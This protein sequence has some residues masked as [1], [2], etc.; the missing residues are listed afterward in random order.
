M[1]RRCTSRPTSPP[2]EGNKSARGVGAVLRH[3]VA[4][5]ADVNS[6]FVLDTP[7]FTRSGSTALF[8]ACTSLGAG[9]VEAIETL[10]E[11]GAVDR[12]SRFTYKLVEAGASAP[13][14]PH[15]TT[16]LIDAAGD[17]LG[18]RP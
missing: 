8:A 4:L 2:R 15:E 18:A 11:L 5:G 7:Q 13:P 9:V 17:S 10:L 3:L 14:Q 6:S 1:L 16:V 12:P